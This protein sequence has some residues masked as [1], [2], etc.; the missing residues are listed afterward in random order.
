MARQPRPPFLD[1][2]RYR[3]ERIRDAA[4][5]LPALGLA[6][7]LVPLAWGAPGE[8]GAP[9]NAAALLYLFGLWAV[10]IALAALLSRLLRSGADGDEP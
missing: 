8:P 7:L 6:L 4:R 2:R 3:I 5:L 9:G 1:R 10:L